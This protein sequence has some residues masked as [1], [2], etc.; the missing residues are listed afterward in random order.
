MKN[1]RIFYPKIF[2]FVVVKF[3]VCLNRH[4]FVMA[5][6]ITCTVHAD[7]NHGHEYLQNFVVLKIPSVQ[8]AKLFKVTPNHNFLHNVYLG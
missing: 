7:V 8:K 1:I 6:Y 4:V 3:S 2:I 5:T